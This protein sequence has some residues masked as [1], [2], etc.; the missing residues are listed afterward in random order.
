MDRRIK[1]EAI[2][3]KPQNLDAIYYRDAAIDEINLGD[4]ICNLIN[5]WKTFVLV[6]AIG[7][8]ASIALAYLLPRVYLVEATLRIPSVNEMGDL[9]EQSILE[10]T[11]AQSLRRVADQLLAP[12]VQR[13]ALERSSWLKSHSEDS[14]SVLNEMA[15]NILN[16]LSLDVLRHDYYE[17]NKDEKT[18]FREISLSL[19]SSQSEL[20]AEYLATLIEHAHES[21][22]SDLT[23]DIRKVRDNRIQSLEDNLQTLSLAE[24]QIRE[25]EISRLEEANQ[26]SIFKLQQQIDLTVRKA[27]LDRENRI[28]QLAEARNTAESLGISEPVTWDDLRPMRKS[29][30]ITNELGGNDPSEP[31]YFR[32]TRLLDAELN[33]LRQREDDKPFIGD[34]TSLEKEII[35]LQNDPRIATL[36]ARVSDAIFTEQYDDLQRKLAELAVQPTRFENGV[37]AVVT[38]PP[39]IPSSPIRNPLLIVLI[40]VLLSVF[41]ALM[42]VIIRISISNS[43]LSQKEIPLDAQ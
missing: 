10:I 11:P 32:G 20:V 30:Q 14:E 15:E 23:N 38:R 9:K 34:L 16:E 8:A 39:L 1:L 41:V 19:P 5:E 35:Q 40:G 18:P 13:E 37:M 25:A 12:N 17:L 6:M 4:L 36:K 29:A 33:L 24:K 3:T 31:L 43:D 26:E 22:L 2:E 42:V 28:I 7:I 27:R 21:A